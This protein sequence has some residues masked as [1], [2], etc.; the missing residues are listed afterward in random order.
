MKLIRRIGTVLSATATLVAAV[1]VASMVGGEAGAAANI[2]AAR[3]A[4]RR[5]VG[6]G[7][8][9]DEDRTARS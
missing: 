4:W 6:G 1:V 8:Q 5:D 9:I 3:Q 7:P 2:M